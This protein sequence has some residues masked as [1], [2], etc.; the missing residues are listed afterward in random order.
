MPRDTARAGRS[1]GKRLAVGRQALCHVGSGLLLDDGGGQEGDRKDDGIRKPEARTEIWVSGFLCSSRS[2]LLAACLLHLEMPND[3]VG[4]IF[5]ET[6]PGVAGE[7][8]LARDR[9]QDR[10]R[11][12]VHHGVAADLVL[13]CRA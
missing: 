7:N 13:G 11:F 1:V 10:F 8:S 5:I 2:W 9:L 12:V 6:M 4:D 3:T